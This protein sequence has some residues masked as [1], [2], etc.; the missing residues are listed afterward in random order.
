[1]QTFLSVLL[2]GE[3]S[4]LKPV[5]VTSGYSEL[6]SVN[7]QETAE[8]SFSTRRKCLS[9]TVP[10]T[11]TP[12]IKQITANSVSEVSVHNASCFVNSATLVNF[13]DNNVIV[14]TAAV[15]SSSQTV[16]V[17]V[18]LPDTHQ[19]DTKASIATDSS[20]SVSSRPAPAASH[21]AVTALIGQPVSEV[22]SCSSHPVLL[23]PTMPFKVI[24][25]NTCTAS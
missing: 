20:V 15:S 2:T 8:V 17:V 23:H 24:L 14:T 7:E 3:S 5:N 18:P 22:R 6:N 9:S 10:Q 4:W 21:C 25:S 12:D 16:G 1:M 11:L 19:H 13:A